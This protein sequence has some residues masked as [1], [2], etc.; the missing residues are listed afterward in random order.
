MAR[1]KALPGKNAVLFELGSL[2]TC[3]ERRRRCSVSSD[4]WFQ[5]PIPFP[6]QAFGLLVF[7]Q[8]HQ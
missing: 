1:G 7:H 3:A 2:L 5:V 4:P 6:V 8:G